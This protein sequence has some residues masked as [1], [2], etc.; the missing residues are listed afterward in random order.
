MRNTLR[1]RSPARRGMRPGNDEP[2]SPTDNSSYKPSYDSSAPDDLRQ[3]RE[4]RDVEKQDPP[5]HRDNA[6]RKSWAGKE[7]PFGD[8]EGAEVKY[9][10]LRW[11]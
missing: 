6:R 3:T 5:P 2:T 1:G 11:W 4:L 10:T 8:E 7:D 9:R